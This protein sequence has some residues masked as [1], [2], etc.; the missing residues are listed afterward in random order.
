M[1]SLYHLNS[2]LPAR[3]SLY[4]NIFLGNL[5]NSVAAQS[6]LGIASKV[7][8]QYKANLSELINICFPLKSDDF[9]GNRSYLIRLTAFNIRSEI[10]GRSLFKV[11]GRDIRKT[12]M[13]S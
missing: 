12:P 6:I 2:W 7:Y 1:L 10:Q 4:G 13:E 9:R 11:N 8:F 5:S 3:K